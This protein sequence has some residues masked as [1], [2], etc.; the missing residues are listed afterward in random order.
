MKFHLQTLLD[1]KEKQLQQAGMLGQR[2]LAQ[3]TE[4]EERIRQLQELEGDYELVG[5]GGG[6]SGA[7]SSGADEQELRE[8]WEELRAV[9]DG[10]DRENAQLSSA[11]GAKV[12]S[13][14]YFSPVSLSLAIEIGF[15]RSTA[16]RCTLV[17]DGLETTFGSGPLR[18][19]CFPPFALATPR[20]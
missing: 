8:R 3:Q 20:G 2:V 10:W 1:S 7:A 16:L 6:L 14:F 11:F 18:T 19:T 17:V 5:T 15:F 13:A 12:S 9:I 4:L